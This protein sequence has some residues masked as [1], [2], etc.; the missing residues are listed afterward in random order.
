MNAPRKSAGLS[1]S[2]AHAGARVA[3]VHSALVLGIGLLSGALYAAWFS[4]S[5]RVTMLAVDFVLVGAAAALVVRWR[6][7]LGFSTL[8]VARLL[9][10]VGVVGLSLAAVAFTQWLVTDGNGV[11]LDESNYLDTLRRGEIVRDGVLPFNVRWLVPFVAGR[12]N[13]LPV[14]DATALKAV[15]FAS[16]V[17]TCV[18]LVLL[19]VRLRV[20]LALA[21]TAPLVLMSSYLGQYAAMNRLVIDAFNYATFVLLFHALLRPEHARW[22]GALLLLA[23]CNSEKAVVWVPLFAVVTLLRSPRPWTGSQL[24][25]AASTVLRVC[26]P[27]LLYTVAIYLYVT[28]SR[29]EFAPCI[30]VLNR[31]SFT[32]VSSSVRNP[33]AQGVSLQ[34]L[35]FPF[36]PFTVFAALAL[37]Y[38]KPWLSATALLLAPVFLQAVLA[39]DTQRMI[40]YSFIVFLPLGYVYLAA[41]LAGMPRLLATS[42]GAAL[43]ALIVVE[44]FLFPTLRELGRVLPTNLSKLSM[45]TLEVVLVG[46]VVLLHHCLYASRSGRAG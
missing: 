44:H 37:P 22:F 16:L 21:L 20:P 11:W 1:L 15:N 18:F 25:A 46:A 26:W 28:P 2:E 5:L 13:L 45:S 32:A 23:A 36:G 39:T 24:R 7:V 3:L 38:C 29:R 17:V 19:L 42:L 43:T 41:A 4:S 30:D 10:L 12:W 14:D 33:C 27:A 35:W 40:A 34:M 8:G 6:D 31:L 9:K